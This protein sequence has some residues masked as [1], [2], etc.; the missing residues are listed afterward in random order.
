[1]AR[2][3][4][5]KDIEQ[6]K[7]E[8]ETESGAETSAENGVGKDHNKLTEK[9]EK[10]LFFHHLGIVKRQ[11][12]RAESENGTLR[13]FYKQAKA[14]GYSKKDIDFALALEKDEDDKMV[15]ERRRQQMI[16]LWMQHSIGTQPDMFDLQPDRTPSVDRAYE[17]GE[18]A[19]MKGD[20]MVS[21]H[22]ENTEQGQAW[23][24][25]WH[26]GQEALFAIKEMKATA[27][28]IEGEDDVGDSDSGEPLPLGDAEP[29]HAA[30]AH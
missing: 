24:R 11:K 14:D 10:A 16:A 20:S 29:T 1:M 15:E 23:M 27:E 8:T 2:R 3:R 7:P 21:P 9:Q 17:A 12:D 18:I 25:G 26:A 28:I 5:A 30:T 19:G 13:S 6:E 4:K 22:A